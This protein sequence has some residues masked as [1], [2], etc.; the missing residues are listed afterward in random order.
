MSKRSIIVSHGHPNNPSWVEREFKRAGMATGG[1]YT[2][3][4]P[5]CKAKGSMVYMP[6]GNQYACVGCGY[7]H[8][9]VTINK[10]AA[11]GKSEYMCDELLHRPRKSKGTPRG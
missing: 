10:T 6:D 4:C 5:D 2:G 11:V 8:T 1:V 3:D 7:H 9:H